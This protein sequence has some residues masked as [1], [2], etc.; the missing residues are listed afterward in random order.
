[1]YTTLIDNRPQHEKEGSA[2]CIYCDWSHC[3]ED[4]VKAVAIDFMQ[5]WNANNDECDHLSWKEFIEEAI[6]VVKDDSNVEVQC[7]HCNA[8]I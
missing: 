5:K 6:E 8:I 1:M 3:Y 7:D 2:P 4:E